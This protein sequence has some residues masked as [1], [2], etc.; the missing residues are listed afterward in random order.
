MK[1]AYP[2]QSC[3][4]MLDGSVSKITFPPFTSLIVT[5]NSADEI[6]NLLADLRQFALSQSNRVIV[7]DNASQDK[8]I[9]IVRDQY[10]E[11]ELVVNARNVGYAQAVNQGFELCDTEYVLLL[12]PDMRITNPRLCPTMLECLEQYPQVAVVA[13]LQFKQTGK[14]R[15]LNFTWSYW[16]LATFRLY[17][18]HI[19][20]FGSSVDAPIS[21]T[22]L[23]AGCLLIRMS[24]FVRV[25]K[26]NEKYFLYG[27]EPDLFLKLKR[28]GYEC[29]LL[30]SVEVVHNRERSL[31]TV[32]TLKRLLIRIRGL[33]NICD[34][35]VVGYFQLILALL[36]HSR[37][38]RSFLSD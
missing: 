3:P 19:L 17:L 14:G 25:G 16:T 24:S 6:S 10:P 22:F 36:F 5:Y 15:Q 33:Y 20:D 38:E 29:R 9:D 23:N 31:K 37:R 12:N 13:P 35:L 7:I 30:P 11:V 27:E 34:A 4:P 21:V 2:T 8:T 32:P 1:I 28:Y 26:L 18:S